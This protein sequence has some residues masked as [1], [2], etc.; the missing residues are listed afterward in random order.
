MFEPAGFQD[1]FKKLYGSI[2]ISACPVTVGNCDPKMLTD[3]AKTI[4]GGARKGLSAQPDSAK[5]LAI[6]LQARGF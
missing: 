3:P 6:Q 4:A 2:G 5:F 1:R